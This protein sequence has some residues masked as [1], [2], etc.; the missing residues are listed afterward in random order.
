MTQKLNLLRLLNTLAIA[1]IFLPFFN[2]C[3]TVS[4]EKQVPEP[5]K[6][7]E[8]FANPNN[9]FFLQAGQKA[10]P[11]WIDAF[12]EDNAVKP[13]IEPQPFVLTGFSTLF[14][15]AFLLQTGNTEML[16]GRFTEVICAFSIVLWVVL[17][18]LGTVL[19]PNTTKSLYGLH[20]MLLVAMSLLFLNDNDTELR[21]GFYLY[22]LCSFVAL[23]LVYRNDVLPQ[24]QRERAS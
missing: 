4:K 24:R 22:M 12:F 9:A 16:G 20:T 2:F 15:S 3:T 17:A 5:G 7:Y 23:S 1:T 6:K 19:P 18:L 11:M 21:Y 8:S 14:T 10:Q 13:I